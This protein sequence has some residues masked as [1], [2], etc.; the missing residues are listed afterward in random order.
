M[1]LQMF[2]DAP[3]QL[4]GR[5][6]ADRLHWAET[7]DGSKF[8][9]RKVHQARE[10]AMLIQNLGRDV[11]RRV[12][13]PA[14]SQEDRKYFLIGAKTSALLDQFPAWFHGC[15]GGREPRAQLR[16]GVGELLAD[17]LRR[18]APGACRGPRIS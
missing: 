3:G 12:T 11:L 16:L 9:Q 7:L 6:D 8:P 17:V 10:I 1:V 5:G 4:E 18:I 14:R 15:L 13:G 2:Y